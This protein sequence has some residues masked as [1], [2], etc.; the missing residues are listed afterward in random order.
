MVQEHAINDSDACVDKVRRNHRR[1][2]KY[3]DVGINI[4][5]SIIV[6]TV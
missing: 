6:N 2:G 4:D 1:D 5:M 3:R